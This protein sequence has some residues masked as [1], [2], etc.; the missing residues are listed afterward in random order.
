[1]IVNYSSDYGGPLEV[2]GLHDR[3]VFAHTG[4]NCGPPAL[5]KIVE[6]MTRLSEQ[7]PGADVMASTL[8]AFA[9]ELLPHAGKLPVI[10]QEIGDT[11]IHGGATDPTKMAMFRQ[12]CRLRQQWQERGLDRR[13]PRQFAAFSR[14]LLMVPE[15]T[16][17]LD[18]KTHLGDYVHYSNRAFAQARQR[19]VVTAA[20]IPDRFATYR[21]FP[22]KG[23]RRSYKHFEASW[24]EQRQYLADAV[25]TLG[26]TPLK[27]RA[28][29]ALR[30]L[31]P[32]ALPKSQGHP[33]TFS[34]PLMLGPF[35]VQFSPATGAIIG[36]RRAGDGQ[37]WASPRN[38]LGLFL[39]Q[40][41][42]QKSYDRWL[43][44]YAINLGLEKPKGMFA[45]WMWAV[46]DLS[47]PGIDTSV[48]GLREA[49]H[50]PQ[51]RNLR[52][53]R[54][55]AADAVIAD[56]VMP[57][58]VHHYAGAPQAIRLRWGFRRDQPAID[59]EVS[60][61]GKPGTRLPEAS[62]L[63]FQPV[64]KQPECWQLEKMG[65]LVSPL[66]VVEHGNRNLHAV[67]ETVHYAGPDGRLSIHTFYAPLIAPG[68]PRL[69]HFD[70]T[71]PPLAAGMHFN[72]HN[73]VWGTN[74]PMWYGD[75]ACFRFRLARH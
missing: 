58:R 68:K 75:D 19:N 43:K 62:W 8:D 24:Q 22:R 3:L 61:Y 57:A 15:H 72:L 44:Q 51:C 54:Q 28:L 39:Y 6:D 4:D 33:T 42:S 45:N 66:E 10:H 67:G 7:N 70:D 32:V 74:F 37:Q 16:W 12:L 52:V 34:K 41:F 17:G 20:A 11:W 50:K 63:S 26:R 64:V 48:P 30:E 56:L 53:Y 35:I 5:E 71:P 69:L 40:T 65:L 13:Y 29:H 31:K 46:P 38:P 9:R 25:K 18:E 21:I 36:L 2:A 59:L 23:V 1:M 47:K 49:L 27:A 55:A 73:N 60:W 14:Q